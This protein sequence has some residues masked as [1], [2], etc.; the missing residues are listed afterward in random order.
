MKPRLGFD[1]IL[2]GAP[3][4]GK[5]TQAR[6][7]ERKFSL[8]AVESGNYLRSLAKNKTKVGQK[9]RR[10]LEKGLPAPTELV[11]EFLTSTLDF[12]PKNADLMF[13]G[14]PRLK[15]EAEFLVKELGKRQ[16]DFIVLY[17]TLPAGEIWKRSERRMRDDSDIHHIAERISWYRKRVNLTAKYFQKLGKLQ[18]I[19]GAQ[20][21]SAV[22]RE[23]MK[24]IYDYKKFRTTR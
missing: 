22:S 5:D 21:I 11:N 18:K 8:R 9:L 10:A 17:I 16:R 13:V 19:N 7:L 2:L 1:I 15:P 24:V 23:I 6:L 3:A 20:T 12:A 4:S 14:N